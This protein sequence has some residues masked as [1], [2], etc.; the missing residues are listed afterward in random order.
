MAR[1]NRTVAPQNRTNRAQSVRECS[2]DQK[3]NARAAVAEPGVNHDKKTASVRVHNTSRRHRSA[4]SMFAK[5]NHKRVA[6]AIGFALTLG[7]ES[8][9]HGLTIILMGRLTEAERA[10]LAFA[11]LNSLSEKHAYM[12][13]SAALFGTLYGEGER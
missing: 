1:T 8:A 13:A 11:T 12:T 4:M 5:G 2:G 9:W 10:A 6:K 7:T 3:E